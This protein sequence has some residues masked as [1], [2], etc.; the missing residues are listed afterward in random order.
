MKEP[1]MNDV[2]K[3]LVADASRRDFIKTAGKIAI[4]APA[5][6]LLL[7]ASAASATSTNPYGN[8]GTDCNGGTDHEIPVYPSYEHHGW[9]K[10][11]FNNWFNG[12]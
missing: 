8:G 3:Q 9:L 10:D 1:H 7:R 6:A 12:R 4:T 2:S 5:V 11:W